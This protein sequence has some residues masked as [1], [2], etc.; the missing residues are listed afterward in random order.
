MVRF[1]SMDIF[2]FVYKSWDKYINKVTNFFTKKIELIKPNKQFFK[3]SGL[4]L[5]SIDSFRGLM[6]LIMIW[7]H[8]CDWWLIEPDQ[9]FFY[10]N[11]IIIDRII[12]SGGFLFISGLSSTLFVRKRIKKGI[13]VRRM[14]TEYFI[15]LL[16][17]LMIAIV[18]NLF[19]AI[20][21]GNPSFTWMWFLL[22]TLSISLMIIWPLLRLS[23]ISRL[24]LSILI[25]II[26]YYV[27]LFLKPSQGQ[28]NILGI[29]YH[30]LY[31]AENL[32]PILSHFSYV[33]IGTVIA[34]MI[35]DIISSKDIKSV[36]DGLK[37]KV[38]YPLLIIGISLITVGLIFEFP[39]STNYATFSWKAISLGSIFI[40]FFLFLAYEVWKPLKFK[41]SF[42][43]LYLFSYYSL[44]TYLGHL[45]LYLLFPGRLPLIFAL[46]IIPGTIILIF[47]ILRS[48]YFSKWR[49][50]VS[51]KIQLA[52]FAGG[53][54]KRI[55]IRK[56]YHT[57][58]MKLT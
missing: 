35:F 34:D 12:G 44:T 54:M 27:L 5:Q 25:W 38:L 13:N 9:G 40:V 49:N 28:T 46:F 1:K 18:F 43:F 17:I 23:K 55:E 36:K 4:R 45:T 52:R 56:S 14:R 41:K 11:Y 10:I 22:F 51:I 6:I 30:L 39:L 47:F 7:M 57:A 50:Y 19:V 42:R 33:L 2:R 8:L 15:R 31:N 26:N 16:F 20:G 21:V 53:I 24:I 58:F 32:E 3:L 48:L 29:L 37:K